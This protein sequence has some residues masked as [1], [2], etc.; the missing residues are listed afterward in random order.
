MRVGPRAG[1]CDTFPTR[2][3]LATCGRASGERTFSPACDTAGAFF[4]IRR[5]ETALDFPSLV[6]VRYAFR[7]R[8]WLPLNAARLEFD[9][10]PGE[11]R[12]AVA[13]AWRELLGYL[14]KQAAKAIE[15]HEIK[16]DLSPRQVATLIAG[17]ISASDNATRLLGDRHAIR[18]AEHTFERLFPTKSH[19]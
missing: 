2:E 5:T 17:L 9:D 14:E 4:Q 3:S 11:V 1:Y 18:D 12:D 19:V 6:A 15:Q 7:S 8:G 10:Q 13:T 16:T